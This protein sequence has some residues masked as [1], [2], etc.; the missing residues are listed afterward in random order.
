MSVEYGVELVDWTRFQEL[1]AEHGDAGFFHE[2]EE[3]GADWIIRIGPQPHWQSSWKVTIDFSD[4]FKELRQYLSPDERRKFEEFFFAFCL[5]DDKHAFVPPQ[6][7][8][9]GIDEEIFWSTISPESARRY[10]DLWE[11]LD[12][13]SLRPAFAQI[14][15]EP[16]GHM[17]TFEHFKRYPEMWADL[18]RDAVAKKAGIVLTLA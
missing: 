1:W 6:D 18:L 11:K 17:R 4:T 13:E 9:E 16:E 14:E 15:P 5:T 2:A 8:G 12:M 3:E 7:L 10:L